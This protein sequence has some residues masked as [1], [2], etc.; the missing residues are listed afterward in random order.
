MQA[1]DKL[2]DQP[3]AGA[4]LERAMLEGTWEGEKDGVK[5]EVQFQWISEH[6]QVRWNVQTPNAGISAQ[7]SVVLEPDGS[8]AKFIFRKGVEF[9]ATL[10][11]LTLGEGGTMRLEIVPN[12]NPSATKY[13]AVEGLVLKKQAESESGQP[14]PKPEPKGGV[15]EPPKPTAAA[16]PKL[17][18]L[19]DEAY[20]RPGFHCQ[21]FREE[22]AKRPGGELM[23]GVSEPRTPAEFEKELIL[24]LRTASDAQWRI[25]GTVK[26]GLVV[27]SNTKSDVKFA[28]SDML[29]SGLS[30][31]AIDEV[32]KEHQAD[33]ARTPFGFVKRQ[34]MLLPGNS[35]VATV[36][37]FTLRFDAEKRPVTEPHIA[38]FHL[39]PGKYTL[40]CKWSDASPH[41]A[42]EGEWS[43]ELVSGEH[44]FTLAAAVGPTA[45]TTLQPATEQKL[46]WGESVKGLRMALAWPPTLGEPTMGAAQ[47]FYLVV[48]N[49]SEAEVRF[50][51]GTAAPNPRRLNLM[52]RL[53]T[54]K[55]AILS[56]RFV[57]DVPVAGDWLLQPRESALVRLIH[58]DDKTPDGQ[59][60]SAM[61]ENIVSAQPQYSYTADMTIEKAPAGA[62]TGM[63]TTGETRG[64]ADVI[65]T[66]H[67]DA[68]TLY[69][70]WT[71]AARADGNIPG[72][73]IGR[74]GESVKTFIKI[75]PTSETTPQ[76]EKML[77]RFD[78][79]HDWSR[80]DTVALLDELAA[81]GST[82][83]SMALD[84]ENKGLIRPGTPL[85]PELATA[86]WGH[87]VSFAPVA[88][89]HPTGLRVAWLLEPQAA[90]HR[91]GTPL[92][93]RV[94]I[95]NSGTIPVVFRTRSWHQLGH[96][97]TDAQGAEI[98]VDATQ[99]TTRA[100]LHWYRLAP[101]EF[102]EVNGP[103]IGVGPAG[104]RE[105]WQNAR[106]GSWI[107]AK[108]GDDVTVTTAELP[109]MDWGDEKQLKMDGEM[110]FWRDKIVERLSRHLP[111]PADADSR[112]RLLHRVARE[113]FG[114]SVSQEISDAFVADTKPTALAS[115][116]ERLHHRPGLHA[117]AG[118]LPSAPT[119]FRVLPA[120]QPKAATLQP[121]TEQKLDWSEPVNGLRLALAWPPS[122][123]EPAA[124]AVADFL[125]V[126][127][128]VSD[129]PVRLYTKAES[130][131]E[132]WVDVRDDSGTLLR[133]SSKEASGVDVTLQP[134]QV[135]VFTLL[136]EGAKQADRAT[137]GAMVA[138]DVRQ[139]PKLKLRAG[140]KIATA[141]VGAWSGKLTTPDTRA[142]L[143]VEAPANRKAQELLKIWIRHAR[144]NGSVPG[145]FIARLGEHVKTFVKANAAD[146]SGA[147]FAKRMEPLLPRLDG[148]RDW[149]PAEATVLMNEIAA[150]SDGV[151]SV[152]LN[153]IAAGQVQHGLLWE[154][155]LETAP[156]GESLPNGLRAAC[157]VGQGVASR[158]SYIDWVGNAVTHGA[159]RDKAA[160]PAPGAEIP[161]GTSL[162]CRWLIHNAGKEPVVFRVRTWHHIEPTAKDSKGAAITMDSHTRLTVP[163][164]VTFR[165]EPDRYIELPGPGLGLGKYGFHDFKQGDLATW[166]DAKAG[167]EVTLTPGPLPLQDW[168]ESTAA[169]G[170]P[171]WWLDFITSR[172]GYMTPLPVD[173]A[174]RRKLLEQAMRDLFLQNV[175]PTEEETASF[176]ADTSPQ[177]LATLAERLF[178]RP[179]VHAWSGTLQSGPT[180]FRVL[181]A[182]PKAPKPPDGPAS[183]PP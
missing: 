116:A 125:A 177:S 138:S 144:H 33:V 127:Q 84:D 60:F 20:A 130:L 173:A 175:V 172:L 30:I 62:W 163:S 90:E 14:V 81:L 53:D 38:S 115:L 109:L 136:P 85:P 66:K 63:M 71:T 139:Q 49:V 12:P 170:E 133:L 36:K 169:D 141:P 65:P 83:I 160:P 118:S 50:T 135:V 69:K 88:Y 26:V 162:G 152:M 68:Q 78:A 131:D 67:V 149:P 154:K 46:K 7:M 164:L 158:L 97:A 9:E 31:V 176:L 100:V 3:S 72:A 21:Q 171:R 77:P 40:R 112:L 57:D 61:K 22:D 86:P 47:E 45:I 153:E 79:S 145:G 110:P 2:K 5:V 179:G 42:H 143:N 43:G 74:L 10:G 161:L 140:L 54:D 82:P 181:P 102:I 55:E 124:G 52:R 94:L 134:R 166:M 155:Q 56:S 107:E 87:A 91:L 15:Q 114:T 156:W 58:T 137:T 168:N 167:D 182:D 159:P 23:G 147:P 142:G 99:S 165:L 51:T 25:A 24:G 113:L 73:L 75:N 98:K 151:L 108:A 180:K 128:N 120:A 44:R 70:A 80:L 34:Q 129:A 28:F 11:R 41:D 119:K 121:A 35:H 16:T 48:Q 148:S 13:P 4:K 157:I 6:Q 111:L 122:L 92:K 27:R 123:G 103:G 101:G 106:V 8:L 37:E 39:P 32:G 19:P 117:W 146:A 150:V 1:A 174:N 59:T 132:R 96:K 76:L 183:T 93:A 95:H 29:D 89:P 17:P 18:P 126:V 64:A 178:H 105:D 104:N